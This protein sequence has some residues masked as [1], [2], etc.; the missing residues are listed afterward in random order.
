MIK[1]ITYLFALIVALFVSVNVLAQGKNDT[2]WQIFNMEEATRWGGNASFDD[3]TVTVSFKGNNDRWIDIPNLKG[4]L[5]GHDKMTIEV[6]KSNCVMNVNLRYKDAEGKTKQVTCQTFWGSMAKNINGKK[7]LKCDLT[8]GGKIPAEYF[9]DVV[10]I[11]LAMA[12]AVAGEEEPW[13][14]QFGKV[15]VY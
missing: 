14:I 12:K 2:P 11:R 4:D 1:K 8:N 9:K 6:L 15:C 7:V 10:G 3:E 13:N 5:T